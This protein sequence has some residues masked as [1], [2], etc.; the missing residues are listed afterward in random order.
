MKKTKKLFIVFLCFAFIIGS[1]A[2]CVNFY[3]IG[4][5]QKYI[6]EAEEIK[7]EKDIDF[8]LVLGCGV[9]EDGTPSHM[10]YERVKKGAE[11][12][13]NS[14]ADKLLL[15]GDRSGE[16]YDEPG[17]MKKLAIEFGVSKKDIQLDDIGFSTY[18]S[19]RNA[20]NI[21]NAEKIVIITQPYHLPRALYIANSLG[22][23]AVGAK[24]YLPFYP[25]QVLWSLRE[26]LA[27]NKD[28]IVCN[29]E[30]YVN[31]STEEVTE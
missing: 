31:I 15:S 23:E 1:Y 26:V 30:K 2:L 21:Y 14:D 13:L 28:F 10:L 3:I 8:V 9:K 16:S 4:S 22:L 24:A 7:N 6:T 5:A 18:E 12:F 29:L 20:K 11:I 19:I 25:K 17:V 27:R